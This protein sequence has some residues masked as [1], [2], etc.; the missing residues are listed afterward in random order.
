M[1]I[2]EV[3]NEIIT[4]PHYHSMSRLF[5]NVDNSTIEDNDRILFELLKNISSM[6]THV[7]KNEITFNPMFTFKDGSRSFAIEDITETDY[8]ILEKTELDRLPLAL[9][10]LISDILWTQRKNYPAS[11]IA[12][13]SYWESFQQVYK[14]RKYYEALNPLKRAVCISQQIK[15]QALYSKIY[16]WFCNTFIGEATHIDAFCALRIMEL[17][18]EQKSTD[19]SLIIKAVDSIISLNSNDDSVLAIEQAY[20]L[21]AKCY[22]KLNKKNEATKCNLALAQFYYDFAEGLLENDAMGAFRSVGFYE[23]AIVLFRNN[24]ASAQAE[25]VHRKLIDVQKQIPKNMHIYRTTFDVSKAIENIETNMDGLSFEECIIRLTQYLGFESIDTIKKR[26]IDECKSDP[27]SSLFGN[28]ILDSQGRTVIKL[29]PLD[30]NNPEKDSHLLELHMFHSSLKAQR[31]VG[32]FWIK[33]ILHYIRNKFTIDNSKIDFLINNNCII[34]D[35]REMIFRKGIGDFLR[36]DYYVAMHILAPQMENLFRNIA[37]EVG[38][39]TSTLSDDG[40]AQ[41]KVLSS[42]FSLPELLDAYDNNIIFAFRGLLNEQAG[43]NI[44]NR[45]AHGIIDEAECS[46]GECLYFGALV[47]KLLSFTALA[48]DDIIN[49]NDRI[50]EF[51]IPAKDAIKIIKNN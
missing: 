38:G 47:I 37:N 51:K 12:A 13:Q 31:I 36:G 43:A 16:D 45:I 34:P 25:S 10:S 24:G 30:E 26:T 14:V 5:A 3:L 32:D 20:E 17:F 41:E 4:E 15:F 21:E 7:T 22:N 28:N 46:S 2:Y 39:V 49:K 27:L 19:L 42:V 23:K 48:C 40:L 1:D 35:G 18:F 9:R 8:Q 29:S 11:Q 33:N 50:K 44:R 6:G